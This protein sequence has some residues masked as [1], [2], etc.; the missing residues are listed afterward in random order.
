ML[1]RAFQFQRVCVRACVHACV[2]EN[3]LERECVS[4]LRGEMTCLR[5]RHIASPWTSSAFPHHPAS[6]AENQL[7]CPLLSLSPFPL[8]HL[9]S[10]FTLSNSY[11]GQICLTFHAIRQSPIV[12]V[13]DVNFLRNLSCACS[14]DKDAILC[15]YV[16]ILLYFYNFFSQTKENV[17]F[18]N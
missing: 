7:N 16:N 2:C 4:D 6:R 8:S 1:G 17:F 5:S 12:T 13:S 10:S 18:K 14:L 15:Y 11:G 3:P 9:K